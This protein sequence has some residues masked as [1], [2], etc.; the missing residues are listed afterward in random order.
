[1]TKDIKEYIDELYN[2]KISY[3]DLLDTCTQLAECYTI[4]CDLLN[5]LVPADDDWMQI[6]NA[7]YIEMHNKMLS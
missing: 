3:D 7:D 4:A 5:D 2:S 6:I 1:M